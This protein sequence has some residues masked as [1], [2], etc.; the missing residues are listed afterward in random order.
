MTTKNLLC[1]FINNLTSSQ[2]GYIFAFL[3][4]Y[5]KSI[6]TFIKKFYL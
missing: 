6:D 5:V 4:N 3:N 2:L 1:E